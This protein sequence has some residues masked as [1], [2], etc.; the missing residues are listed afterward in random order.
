MRSNYTHPRFIAP[1]V[2]LSERV[3][4]AYFSGIVFVGDSTAEGLA[5]H[6]LVP[7]MELLTVIGLSPRTATTNK[8]FSH[9][10]KL[11][12]LAEKLA[13]MQPKAVYLWLGS[14]GVD[15]KPADMVLDDYTTLLNTLLAA[16][17]DTPFILLELTPVKLIA[18]E[19]YRN[20]TNERVDAFNLG[21][22][23]LAQRHNV[24]YLPVNPLLRNEQGL[25]DGEYGAGD[26]IHLRKDGYQILA[27]YLY[28][29][30][31]PLEEEE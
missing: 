1:E 30:T 19:T 14:N 25:L 18:Q 2:P 27:D 6:G 24:Y 11:C 20:Y 31:L 16:L 4:D 5:I 7:E 3:D 21:L 12:T 23:K 28:T 10:R 15:T 9:E 29:H 26:G 17:P 13:A 22:Y 8:V